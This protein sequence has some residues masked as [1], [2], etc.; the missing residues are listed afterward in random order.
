MTNNIKNEMIKIRNQLPL[1]Q[2]K[3]CKYIINNMD[4]IPTMTIKELS[5]QT[6]VGTTTIIR[7]INK[8]GYKKYQDFKNSIINYTLED[9][10]NTWWHLKKSIVTMNESDNSLVKVGND[11]IQDIDHV[12][13]TVNI[14]EYN[15]FIDILTNSKKTYFLGMRTSKSLS[16][17]FEMMLREILDNVK[18]LSW[19]TEFIYD[20]SLK[21]KNDFTLVIIAL[22]PFTTECIEFVKYCK[23]HTSISI[24]LITDVETCPI[25]EDSDAYLIVGQNKNRYSIIPAIILIESLIIDLGKSVPSSITKISKLNKIHKDI[26]ITTN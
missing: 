9:K 7:F 19:N 21:F 1:Q 13:K 25:I 5:A 20:E 6:D 10:K 12:L 16:F 26:N 8:L 18:Q 4:E 2:K 15:Q 17:Y 23:K 24:L 14:D 3:I 22:S 11:S